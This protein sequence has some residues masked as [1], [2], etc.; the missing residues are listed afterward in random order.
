[1]GRVVRTI[2]LQG[3]VL[4]GLLLASAPAFAQDATP[5]APATAPLTAAPATDGLAP[6]GYRLLAIAAGA[7]IGVALVEFSAPA[8]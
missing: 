1:M 6:S 2:R 4:A 8:P 3:I 5:V 7:V